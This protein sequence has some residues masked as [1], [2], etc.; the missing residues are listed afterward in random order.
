[1]ISED[2]KKHIWGVAELMKSFA[3]EQNLSSDEAE[4]YYMLG[5]LHDVGY[6]FAEPKDFQK[7]NVIG[8]GRFEETWI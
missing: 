7:H 6:A 1:M 2:R 8:G 3:E 5:L 4:E